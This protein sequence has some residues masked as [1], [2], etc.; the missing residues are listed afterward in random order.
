[1]ASSVN[2]SALA[3]WPMQKVQQ[4][5]TGIVQMIR[6]S[7]RMHAPSLFQAAIAGVKPYQPVNTGDYKRSGKVKD[8]PDGALFYNPTK[9][10]AIIEHGRRPGKGVSREG[11]E[12]LARWVH[13]HGMDRANMSKR[14]RRARRKMRDGGTDKA[15]FRF[16]SRWQQ[17]TRARGIAFLIARAIKRR[18]LPAKNVIGGMKAELTKQVLADVDGLMVRG[19]A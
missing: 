12:A 4:Y 19:V 7:V 16:R 8:I 9:Q 14:E 11:Q 10:A 15:A 13:L 2:I 18:G 5:H 3:K 1:M 6:T 17:D